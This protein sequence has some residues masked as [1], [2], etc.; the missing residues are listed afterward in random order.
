MLVLSRKPGEHIVL[1]DSD[2]TVT[3]LGIS[4]KKVRLGFAAPPG[5]S[6]HRSEIWDR[7]CEWGAAPRKTNGNSAGAM[8]SKP[9]PP[10]LD[11]ALARSI[12]RRTGGQIGSLRVETTE[13]RVVIHGR[14]RTYHALQLAQAAV[15]EALKASGSGRPE[16]VEFDIEVVTG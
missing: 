8:A 1:P 14:T 9:R 16:D 4:G 2:V 11:A 3:V 7:I 12:T 6:V 10:D 13:G 15:M 5:I